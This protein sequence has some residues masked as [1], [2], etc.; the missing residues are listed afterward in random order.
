ME[1]YGGVELHLNAFLT[2]AIDGGEWSASRTGSFTPREVFLGIHLTGGWV[3]P[4]VC[5]R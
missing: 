4:P 2:S 5:R 1:T 3:D